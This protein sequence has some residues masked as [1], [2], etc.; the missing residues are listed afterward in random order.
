MNSILPSEEFEFVPLE[1]AD[2]TESMENPA[3]LPEE[4][5]S[6]YEIKLLLD[7]D[8]TLGEDHRLK[9]E[10]RLAFRMR[11]M[12]DA[13]RVAYLETPDKEFLNAGW[14]NRVRARTGCEKIRL[15]YKKRFPIQNGDIDAALAAAAA[16]G[17]AKDDAQFPT[18]IDWGFEKMTLSFSHNVDLSEETVA[19]ELPEKH[20]AMEMIAANM[21][22]IENAGTTFS[23]DWSDGSTGSETEPKDPAAGPVEDR[24][25]QEWGIKTL[26]KAQMMGPV[27]FLRYTGKM[28]NGVLAHIEIWPVADGAETQYIVEISAKFKRFADAERMRRKAISRLDKMG[29]LLHTDALKTQMILNSPTL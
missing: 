5:V 20:A 21:P 16:E 10:I 19:N 28:K 2:L 29:I 24:E 4:K 22:D 3:V 11:E 6:S 9:E 1:N 25:K 18:E 8:K 17:L 23:A 27:C 26:L 14:I 7:S 12:A 15:T 13:Y